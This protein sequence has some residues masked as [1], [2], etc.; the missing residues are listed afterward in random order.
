MLS[1]VNE[2]VTIGHAN[3]VITIDLAESDDVYRTRVRE[4]LD[5]PYRTML[6]HFRHEVGHYIQWQHVR[7]PDQVEQYRALFGDERA[8]YQA[9][10]D[11]HYSQGAPPDW[12]A[13][14]ISTYAT[15]HPFED[16]AETW[17]HLMHISDTIDTGVAFGLLHADTV[18]AAAS[19][20][21]LVTQVWV[22]L[23]IA[24]N[25]VN[26]SMGKADL[27][28][29]VLP[30]PVL[31]K[32]AFAASLVPG[33]LHAGDPDRFRDGPTDQSSRSGIG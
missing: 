20:E 11:T 29:F 14:Y 30:R 25:N 18:D 16:F 15:M 26:R 2:N 4:Q 8:D 10:I 17:A 19:I 28:P 22:P 33:G 27:Y 1:S 24:L 3:G 32:L 5:E 31:D 12:Q 21:D 23:S 7:T 9:A 13:S 6:G